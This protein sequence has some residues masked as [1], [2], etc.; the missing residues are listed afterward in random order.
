MAPRH[1]A[2]V[3]KVVEWKPNV[4]DLGVAPVNEARNREMIA[5]IDRSLPGYWMDHRS[6]D[7][8]WVDDSKI[9]FGAFCLHEFPGFTLGLGFGNTIT[10]HGVVTVNRLLHSY[11]GFY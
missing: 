6:G 1:V 4:L 10:Q 2:Y 7:D 3:D 8:Y 11:L 5:F 9:K